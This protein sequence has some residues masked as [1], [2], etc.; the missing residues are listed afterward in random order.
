MKVQKSLTIDEIFQKVKG[1]DLVFTPEASLADAINARVRTPRLGKLAYTPRTYIYRRFQNRELSSRKELFLKII[2]KSDLGWKEA[3]YFLDKV[4]KVWEETGDPERILDTAKFDEEKIRAV[5]KIVKEESNIY[6]EMEEFRVSEGKD[7]C[8]V[9]PWQFNE[10]DRSILPSGAEELDVFAEKGVELPP[11]RVFSS[12]NQLVGA[13]VDNVRRLDEEQVAVVVQPESTYDPLLRSHLRAAGINF[14]VAREIQES[15]TLRTFISLLELGLNYP[16]VKIKEVGPIL[17]KV[18]LKPDR[19]I[20]EE[21][22]VDTDSPQSKKANELLEGLKGES[23]ATAVVRMRQN[24]LEPGRELKEVL[25]ETG[26]WEEPV[27]GASLNKLKYYLDSFEIKTEESSGGLLL[28]NPAGSSY[29]DRETVF[30]LGMS[31]QWDVS[32]EE[33]PWRKTERVRERNVKNFKSLIQNGGN[34][35]YMVQSENLNQKVIPSTYFNEFAELPSFT[36]GKQG[37]DYVWYTRPGPTVCDFTSNYVN[38]SPEGIKTLSK[39]EL[40]SLVRCPRDY[41][42]SQLVEDPDRDY[43]RKGTVIHDF[44]EFYAN[45]PDFVKS[46]GLSVFVDLMVQRMKPIVDDVD[47]SVLRT[48]F[49]LG[50]RLLINYLEDRRLSDGLTFD[51]GDYEPGHGENFLAVEF[52]KEV[53]RKFT[54]MYFRNEAI[55]GR[56]K[57]DLLH[58]SQLVDYKTGSKASP[59]QIVKNSNVDLFEENPDFQALL[60]L[61][62]HRTV[63][64]QQKLDFTFFHVL[65]DT[66]KVLSGEIV[67]D[68]F[69]TT[70]SYYPYTFSE[71]LGQEEVYDLANSSKIRG[72]LLDP[73][74]RERFLGVLSD[75]EFDPGDFYSKEKAESHQA[76]LRRLCEKHLEIGRGKDLTE[77]QLDK[78]TN[79]I[80][81]TSL[82]RLRTRN[83]FRDDVDRFEAFLRKK[84]DDLNEWRS[85]RFPVGDTALDDVSHRDLIMAGEGR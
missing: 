80:L 11:F 9:P 65:E 37:E 22:V 79:S 6:G 71:F 36:D 54:E 48:D 2:S 7:V 81:R 85:S 27:S 15:E 41:Y 70:V 82:Y 83:F 3:S 61:T 45:F 59:Y 8:A 20:E 62:H 64:P 68:D 60:Y 24:D 69:I 57:V 52:D 50:A 18:G 53:K 78:A 42:F 23:Y 56:G 28:A 1:Y 5:L 30:Y 32:V 12:A 40:N 72:K 34:R 14:Q 33:R 58:G 21:Y 77:K 44:A 84:L 39:T 74:G 63:L 73:L 66:G 25:E 67:I 75:L 26:L 4:I 16:R 13:V 31:S 47:L 19:R 49:Q 17:R 38:K 43:F 10:L 76:Q 55:G 51:P 29:I 35:L 46:K